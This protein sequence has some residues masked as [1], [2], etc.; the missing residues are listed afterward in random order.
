[1]DVVAK[2]ISLFKHNEHGGDACEE[3]NDVIGDPTY[4]PTI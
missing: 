2:F 1:L 4:V 3:V